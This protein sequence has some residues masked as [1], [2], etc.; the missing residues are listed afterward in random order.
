MQHRAWPAIRVHTYRPTR[1]ATFSTAKCKALVENVKSTRDD[2]DF[3]QNVRDY[4]AK[5]KY[6]W[7]VEWH[8]WSL[9]YPS[10]KSFGADVEIAGVTSVFHHAIGRGVIERFNP[11][12]INKICCCKSINMPSRWWMGLV[13]KSY[14]STV[15]LLGQGM[16]CTAEKSNPRLG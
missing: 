12:A 4:V 15:G 16:W 8:I 13:D 2:A 11:G 6:Q 14:P 9:L 3:Y 7:S 10:G 5:W 1:M